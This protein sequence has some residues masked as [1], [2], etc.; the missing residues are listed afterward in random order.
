MK[1]EVFEKK[2]K[3]LIRKCKYDYSKCKYVDIREDNGYITFLIK[4]D[5]GDYVD[6]SFY[7]NINNKGQITVTEVK[8]TDLP[9]KLNKVLE[10]VNDA[11]VENDEGHLIIPS[12]GKEKEKEV[13]KKNL[14]KIQDELGDRRCLFYHLNDSIEMIDNDKIYEE[15]K[16][17]IDIN[18]ECVKK[19]ESVCDKFRDIRLECFG[20]P[21]FD[22]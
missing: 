21:L 14:D 20:Q 19:L 17:I 3:N 16:Y 22:E 4:T 6:L 7:Y 2:M 8:Y 5:K 15:L 18:Y 9:E 1:L 10:L 11:M 13:A 12:E